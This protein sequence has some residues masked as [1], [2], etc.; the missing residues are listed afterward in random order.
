MPPVF[1]FFFLGVVSWNSPVRKILSCPSARG[2]G[3]VVSSQLSRRA[4]LSLARV[5]SH[6]CIRVRV[7]N[8]ALYS[9]FAASLAFMYAE[10]LAVS[11]LLSNVNRIA[12]VEPTT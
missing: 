2:S 12:L 9:P 5:V 6:S 1:R 7:L 3:G 11:L 10:R 8:W 4:A